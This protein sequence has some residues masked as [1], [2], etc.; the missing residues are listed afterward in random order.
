MKNIDYFISLLFRNY[1]DINNIAWS[2]YK[3]NNLS[4]SI[5][6]VWSRRFRDWWN[7]RRIRKV[8][9]VFSILSVLFKR[10]KFW[11]KN[12]SPTA[13]IHNFRTL[14]VGLILPNYCSKAPIVD[15]AGM[16]RARREL[17]NF[18]LEFWVQKDGT[19]SIV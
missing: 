12:S 19:V 14:T 3:M 4:E 10:S 13:K 2:H 11:E 16:W 5:K 8:P 17:G 1:L 9:F 6:I 7:K 15:F 18:E